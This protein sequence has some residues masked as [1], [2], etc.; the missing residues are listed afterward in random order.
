[1]SGVKRKTISRSIIS[2]LA[3]VYPISSYASDTP[4]LMDVLNYY[5]VDSEVG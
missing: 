1:M 5:A 4:G 2:I 3:R